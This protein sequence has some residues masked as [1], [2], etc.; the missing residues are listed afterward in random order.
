M[1]TVTL[2]KH[3]NTWAVVL[4]AGDGTRLAALTADAKGV[5]VPKQYCSVDG[6]PTLI[7]SALRRAHQVATRSRICVVVAEYHESY[8]R[9]PCGYLPPENVIVEPRNRG[10]AIGVLQAVLRIL[11]RDP[12]ARI[13][14]LPADHFVREERP[15]ASAMRVAIRTINATRQPLLL[16]G[17]RPTEPDPE[18]GYIVPSVEDG[19]VRRVTDFVEK[20]GA[21]AARELIERGALWNSFIF[22]GHAQTLLC[23]LQAKMPEIVASV[24]EARTNDRLGAE[25]YAATTVLY[26]NLP[27]VDFSRTVI[28]S[29]GPALR[30]VIARSCGWLDL[31]SPRR[32]A[33]LAATARSRPRV[34]HRPSGSRA[35]PIVNLVER[36][37]RIAR[38]AYG[39]S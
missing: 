18:F 21:S 20:P 27:T 3:E 36:L 5:T 34:S 32:V 15:L 28:Q 29:A 8:W 12:Q 39:Q 13:L 4:A 9:S 35:Q 22:A 6:G 37:G 2:A 11:E 7:Q 25:G 1:K 26:R 31:G 33:Q 16:I 19:Q 17:V 24:A 10:T 23:M 30:V 38:P 14:F